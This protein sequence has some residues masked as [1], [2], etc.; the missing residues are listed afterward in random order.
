MA[1][2]TMNGAMRSPTSLSNDDSEESFVVLNNSLGPDITDQAMSAHSSLAS[3]S[4]SLIPM[5]SVPVTDQ[6]SA[7]IIIHVKIY[8]V[9][10]TMTTTQV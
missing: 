1:S 5:P 7:I 3:N 8:S 4:A 2:L 10:Q 6:V 9:V